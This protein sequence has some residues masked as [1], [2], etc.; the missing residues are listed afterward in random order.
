MAPSL[1]AAARR[2]LHLARGRSRLLSGLLPRVTASSPC[3]YS[4]E[5]LRPERPLGLQSTL[6]PLGHPGTLL[7]PEIEL[8]AARPGNR[9]RPVELRRIVKEF[10][11]RRRHRQA[12][13]ISEWM[14][15]KGH[16][17]FVPRDH[18]VHLD[19]VGQVH[20]V[21]AAET[22]F[23]NLSEKDKTEKTYGALLNCYTRELLVDK[24][25]AHFQTMKELGFVFLP[26]SY[27]SIM[28]L[29]TNLGQHEKVPSV[30]AE[31]KS[32]GIVP[33]NF[34]YRI[35]INSY[36]TKADFFGMENT[37]EEMECDPQI[38]VDWNTYAVVASNYIKGDLR[39]K[40][41][42]ALQKA[43]AKID[44]KD[45]DA[46]NHL[47][48][49]Y[50]QLGDKSEVKRLWALQMSNCK[51]HINH[52]YNAMLATLVKLDEIAEAEALL[53]EWE[54]SGNAFD[55]HVPNVLLVGYRQKGLLDKAEML[56]DNFLKKGK[57][58]P[59]ISWTIV[60]IGYAEKGDAGKAYEMMKNAL[61]V[62]NPDR[63]WVP[64]PSMIEMI[65]KYLG[66]EAELKDVESFIDLLK[67]AV[68]MNSEMADALS[69]A[70]AR[71]EKKAEE[72]TED[73]SSTSS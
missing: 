9:I 47:I 34:S 42:S 53:K 25:L 35:C 38:V 70:R 37:L 23:N 3:G 45:P 68:P 46:Y 33:D 41:Y 27:N 21:E 36:G 22:Y 11:K 66:D 1:L 56:L 31:M 12:L 51:R 59:S 20:G 14:N 50:G 8:W 6:S 72:M 7:V 2:L 30:I 64:R 60:A 13:E 43:E 55:F 5:K 69:R 62:Y 15:A 32:N 18:D 67:V 10:R 4:T 61:R 29:Y 39:E 48:S 44:K 49:L 40:A 16:V 28:G 17:K 54:S 58:P 26:R 63:G 24:A 57:K 19:L 71:E 65:L 73:L 52:D